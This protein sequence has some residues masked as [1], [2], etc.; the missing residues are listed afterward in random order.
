MVIFS[1]RVRLSAIVAGLFLVSEVF[2][3]SASPETPPA[4]LANPNLAADAASAAVGAIRGDFRVGESG[5]ASYAIAVMPAPSGGGMA[6]E[7]GLS[8][9][10]QSGNGAAGLGWNIS[11]LSSITRCAQT[12]EAGD[13]RPVGVSLGATDRFCL[14][15]QR[16]I[17]SSTHSYGAD[18][19]EYRLA[20][21]QIV[22]VHSFGAIAG[23]PAWFKVW[24]KDGSISWYGAA[25][26]GGAAH[27][28]RVMSKTTANP[29]FAWNLARVQDSA[30]N[31]M[32]IDWQD[33]HSAGTRVE[34]VPTAVRYGGNGALAP[35]NEIWFDWALRPAVD[36]SFGFAAGMELASTARL[37]A[38]RS[39]AAGAEIRRYALAYRAGT[40][41]TAGKSA[42]ASITECRGTTCYPATTLTWNVGQLALGALSGTT[43]VSFS[44]DAGKTVTYQSPDLNGDGMADFISLEK[45]SG[46]AAPRFRWAM[47]QRATNGTLTFT[48]PSDCATAAN[49]PLMGGGV[50]SDL[51]ASSF[52]KWVLMD[53]N[54][55]GY[56]DIVYAYSTPGTTTRRFYA[57]LWDGVRFGSAI[58]V[59]NFASGAAQLQAL[60]WDGDGRV[61]LMYDAGQG[62]IRVARNMG[63]SAANP[64]ATFA[65]Q[66]S[67]ALLLQ[68][69]HFSLPGPSMLGYP[70]FQFTAERVLDSNGDGLADVILEVREQYCPPGCGVQIYS[71]PLDPDASGEG[72][73]G[74]EGAGEEGAG[75]GGE[76][77]APDDPIESTG[78]ATQGRYILFEMRW[79]QTAQRHELVSRAVL[80]ATAN[81]Q[82]G[83]FAKASEMRI[84][85]LNGDGL[86]DIVY[87][88]LSAS[89]WEYRINTGVGNFKAARPIT[90]WP[91]DSNLRKYVQLVDVNG[92]GHPDGLIPSVHN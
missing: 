87:F 17:I 51:N 47:S 76:A 58:H 62:N 9:N 34:T 36:Q 37:T 15:G 71:V 59:G 19:A 81:D 64:G 24:R 45:Q 6:P 69:A 23:G 66:P 88:N 79:N 14:D 5:A 53:V 20:V 75:E 77:E 91:T 43:A 84:A 11:G 68:P 40:T 27:T 35:N 83:G 54:G 28:S 55:N 74:E 22:R 8:Y 4:P 21:D 56:N 48:A 33:R 72:G 61:D 67:F 78:T 32:L 12:L 44:L 60:D 31:Y 90:N 70:F 85:D 86:A 7:I 3:Q 2:A 50:R 80:A 52:P 10:S 39:L 63:Y 16:L 41:D 46:S 73:A 65:E 26:D 42:L 57:H 25:D 49:C 1:S 18:G 13:P 29:V 92:D 30:G 89:R 82:A 38:I